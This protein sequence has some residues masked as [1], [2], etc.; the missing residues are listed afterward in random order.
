MERRFE[1]LTRRWAGISERLRRLRLYSDV[2]QAELGSVISP[3]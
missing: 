1:V 3:Y 2:L